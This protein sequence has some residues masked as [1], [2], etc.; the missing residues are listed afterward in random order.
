MWIPSKVKEINIDTMHSLGFNLRAEDLY[1]VTNPSI[2]DAV[3]IFGEGC[4]GEVV[5]DKGLI[6]TNYHCGHDAIQALSSVEHDY[7]KNGFWAK[8]NDEEFVT[9][10]GY[11]LTERYR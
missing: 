5:S 8:N 2:K 9:V 7:L 3:V 10:Y 11:F 6:F 4:T 1:S